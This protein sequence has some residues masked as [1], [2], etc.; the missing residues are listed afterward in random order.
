M[1]ICEICGSPDAHFQPPIGMAEWLLDISSH[2]REQALDDALDLWHQFEYAVVT[3]DQNTLF[4]TDDLD[5]IKEQF[6]RK[7][8]KIMCDSCATHRGQ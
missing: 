3:N 5:T 7:G 6:R 8:W 2:P 4:S 1:P